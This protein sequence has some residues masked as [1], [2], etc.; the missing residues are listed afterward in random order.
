[1]IAMLLLFDEANIGD[2]RLTKSKQN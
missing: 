2:D 1:M